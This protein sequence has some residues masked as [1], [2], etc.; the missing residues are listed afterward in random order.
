MNKLTIIGNLTSD[1]ELRTTPNGNDVCTFN[2]AVNR[3]R[4]QNNQNPPADFF[5]VSAWGDKGKVCNTYLS[6]G[7]KVCVV[8]QVS[9]HAFNS[10]DGAA[11]AN[12]EVFAEEVEFLTP[13]DSGYTQVEETDNPFAGG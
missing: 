4:T 6:K 9:V 10:Q 12:L 8:G 5:R 3:R 2:V 11:R 1:P 13:K 7:K